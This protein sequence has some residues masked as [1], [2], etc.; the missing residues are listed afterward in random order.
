MSWYLIVLLI[1]FYIVMWIITSIA[2]TRWTKSSDLGWCFLGMVW[3]L[4][5]VCVPFIAVILFVSKIVDKYGY[6]EESK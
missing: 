2:F 4:A 3:P 5:L 6:K 1:I